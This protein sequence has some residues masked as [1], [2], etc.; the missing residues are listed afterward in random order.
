M[1][2]LLVDL[3]ELRQHTMRGNPP[4]LIG[5]RR[6]RQRRDLGTAAMEGP[7]QAPQ[8]V[9]SGCKRRRGGSA[10]GSR[11]LFLSATGPRPLR[12]AGLGGRCDRSRADRLDR[13]LRGS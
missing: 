10:W 7:R 2:P 1:P 8:R 12:P 13:S 11:V 4:L 3:P 9:E 6:A 5:G